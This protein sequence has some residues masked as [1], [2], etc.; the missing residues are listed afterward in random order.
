MIH[1]IYKKWCDDDDGNVVDDNIEDEIE[2]DI[3]DNNNNIY[4]ST[5][6]YYNYH[7]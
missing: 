1:W 7:L 5:Q 6:S 3:N 4:C 2:N